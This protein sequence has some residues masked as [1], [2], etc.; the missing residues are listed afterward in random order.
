MRGN[1][2][3]KMSARNFPQCIFPPAYLF[4]PPVGVLRRV[5]GG[6]TGMKGWGGASRRS[7]DCLCSISWRQTA[8]ILTSNV[9]RSREVVHPAAS[10][11]STSCRTQCSSV[12]T[13]AKA[14]CT[15]HPASRVQTRSRLGVVQG[16]GGLGSEQGRGVPP[17]GEPG[18]EVRSRRGAT[19]PQPRK[20]VPR[21]ASRTWVFEI[22]PCAHSGGSHGRDF[23]GGCSYWE[24]P[25]TRTHAD[26]RSGRKLPV[27]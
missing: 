13:A 6:A 19:V 17:R 16:W 11:A 7:R 23:D 27:S 9:C 2:T 20:G 1:I 15:L 24:V 10:S 5:L 8:R 12:S 3:H 18:R 14:W 25:G 21:V 22:S 26:V 4:P